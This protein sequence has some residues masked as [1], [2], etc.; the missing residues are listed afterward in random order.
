[1]AEARI[2]A[3]TAGTSAMHDVTE[4]GLATALEELSIAGQAVQIKV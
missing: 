1:M 4:G 2:A 3:A